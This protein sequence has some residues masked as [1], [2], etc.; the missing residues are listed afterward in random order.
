MAG[1]RMI[2]PQSFSLIYRKIRLNSTTS[3]TSPESVG[4]DFP[5]VYSVY[6]P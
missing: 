6:F 3:Q 2:A 5:L 4:V 1:H